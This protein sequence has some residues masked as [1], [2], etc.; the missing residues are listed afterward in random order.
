MHAARAARLGPALESELLEQALH[1]EGDA[2]HVG[3]LDARA[4]IEIDAELVGVI[5]ISG[6]NG[7]RV[8]FDAT[9]VHDPGEPRRIVDDDL[10]GR[11]SRRERQ[12]HGPQ[13]GRTFVGRPLLVEGLALGPVHEALEDDRTVAHPGEGAPDTDR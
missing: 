2:P 8:Q 6:A 10:F 3:P 5:E 11:A 1:L 7:V 13:P 4:R 9:Q 12:R